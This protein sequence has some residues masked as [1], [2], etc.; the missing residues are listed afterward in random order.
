MCA[1]TYTHR[2]T[3]TQGLFKQR[4]TNMVPTVSPMNCGELWLQKRPSLQC[5][6]L[7][8]CKWEGTG[9]V[10]LLSSLMCK[11]K[12]RGILG[13]ILMGE[14]AGFDIPPTL[15]WIVLC[16][17][18]AKGILVQYNVLYLSIFYTAPTIIHWHLFC[19]SFHTHLPSNHSRLLKFI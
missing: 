8:W 9:I 4:F 15:K 6:R 12:A 19:M 13:G 7:Q 10:I 11:E 1:H 16:P 14:N 18:R 5:F 3:Y 2:H 17:P